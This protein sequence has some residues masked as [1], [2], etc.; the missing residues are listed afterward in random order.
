MS[1]LLTRL[2][3]SETG[4]SKVFAMLML[5]NATYGVILH[6]GR[7]VGTMSTKGKRV[8]K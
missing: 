8:I 1:N 2:Q 3:R 4:F 5:G 6:D 7:A